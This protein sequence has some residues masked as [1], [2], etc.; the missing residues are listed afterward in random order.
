[1]EGGNQ[2]SKSEAGKRPSAG[3]QDRRRA[4]ATTTKQVQKPI[5]TCGMAIMAKASAPGRTKT[6]LVPPL[7]FDE[8]AALNTAFLQ[9]MTDNL[10]LAGCHAGIA[11]YVAFAPPCSEEFF[12]RILPPSIDLIGA[13]LP[14]L[15]DCLLSTT[16]EIFERGHGSAVLLNADSPTL[17][18]RFLVEAAKVLAQPGE[19]AV[20]GPSSDGGYYL[21][22]LKTVQS[23]LFEEIAW[24]TEHVAA[25]TLE[26]AR[27][28]NLDVHV[29]PAWYDVDD[30]EDLRRLSGDVRQSHPSARELDTRKPYYP[31]ATA[32]LLANLALG[33][34][35]SGD[36]AG[37]EGKGG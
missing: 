31:I 32:A 12:R 18:T 27:E 13:C 15:G 3:K 21:L 4:P 10:L 35:S 28:I 16:R 5:E 30:V 20:L 33:S 17:P 22:G 2:S 6:R 24:S 36:F 7:T 23:H 11:G 26:R 29:L 34:C 25:Q 19:R 14:N 37:T 9:D 1:M 8:A